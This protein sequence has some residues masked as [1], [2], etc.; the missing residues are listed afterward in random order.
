MKTLAFRG[1]WE[2]VSAPTDTVVGCRWVFTLKY[3]QMDLWIDIR[4]GSW[5]KVIL[6][7]MHRLV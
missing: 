3:C 7:D 4:S 1:T 6:R 5:P 2:L